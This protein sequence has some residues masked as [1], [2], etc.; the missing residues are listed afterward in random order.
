MAVVWE[1][2]VD[3]PVN[4]QINQKACLNMNCCGTM[5]DNYTLWFYALSFSS[6]CLQVFGFGVVA[7][8]YY[9][10]SKPPFMNYQLYTTDYIF[11]VLVTISIVIGLVVFMSSNFNAIPPQKP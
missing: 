4:Q 3:K 5:T 1:D 7:A 9:I 2:D 11:G 10:S 8:M 6:L